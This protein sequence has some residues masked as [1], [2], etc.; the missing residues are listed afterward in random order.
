MIRILIAPDSFKG[1]LSAPQ[2]IKIVE[3]AAF[4]VF[5]QVKTRGLPLSDGGEGLVETM[6]DAFGY[7]EVSGPLGQRV[8]AKYGVLG[9]GKAVMEM[10]QS[11][12]LPLVGEEKDPLRATT[13]GTGEQLKHLLDAGCREIIVGIGGS[14]TN[15]CG[16]GAMRALGMT[17]FDGAG[18]PVPDDPAKM[19][20][21]A[22]FDA[23]KLHPA[24]RGA[25]ITA[26]CDVKNPLIGPYGA[27]AVYGPQKGVCKD[28]FA[29]LENGIANVAQVIKKQT[30]IDAA[31]GEGFGAA[32]GLSAAMKVFLGAELKPG[33]DAVLDMLDFETQ[34]READLVVTG[35]GCIDNQSMEYGKV[36]GGVKAACERASV[37][38]LALCGSMGGGVDAYFQGD[39]RS[40][41]MTA[42]ASPATVNEAIAH[43][44]EW[45]QNAAERMF[46]ILYA[47]MEL[48]G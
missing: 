14:A 26:V 43:A 20:E 17:F 47:G 32:G 34:V 31:H 29:L 19:G 44:E 22:G 4:R 15:D 25:K 39:P 35:E 40:S 16:L 7:V 38:C 30:G 48:Q 37:P 23:T 13:F 5:P 6:A 18:K 12:G 2:V 1:S 46:R 11:S 45:L 10:A 28:N 42:V 36:I 3:R 21:I 9:D 24:L 27:T 33:I 41:I 8:R